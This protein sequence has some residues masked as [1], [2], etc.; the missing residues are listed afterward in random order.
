MGSEGNGLL[1]LGERLNG[2]LELTN[3]LVLDSS[4][5]SGIFAF[6]AHSFTNEANAEKVG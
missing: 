1:A 6:S 5:S 4:S 3:P 2:P